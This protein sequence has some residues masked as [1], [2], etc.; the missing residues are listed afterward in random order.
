MKACKNTQITNNIVHMEDILKM[1]C[2]NQVLLKEMRKMI[3]L[4]FRDYHSKHCVVSVLKLI[5][6]L[7]D[8]YADVEVINIGE[9]DLI[10][11]YRT[12]VPRQLWQRMKMIFVCLISFFGSAFTIVA[13]HNDIGIRTVFAELYELVTGD[14]TSGC[15]ELEVF[16]SIGLA[17]G[18][19]T[20]FNHIGGKRLTNDPTP[21]E[22]SMRN[23]EDDVDKAM[24][25]AMSRENKNLDVD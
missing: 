4:D 24:I 25:E 1:Y 22:V 6:I 8:Q 19:V 16:Y 18:I 10:L 12:N 9:S 11:E 13:F 15:T 23:Y 17:V 14:K 2:Q 7:K 20:F 3:V 21:I 5:E